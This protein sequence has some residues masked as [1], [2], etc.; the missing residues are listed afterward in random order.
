MNET[1]R[2]KEKTYLN[3]GRELPDWSVRPDLHRHWRLKSGR[4]GGAFY[5]LN[6]ELRLRQAI[7]S[8]TF[9]YVNAV[10]GKHCKQLF[11]GRDEILFRECGTHFAA[12]ISRKPCR[13]LF[14][15]AYLLAAAKTLR[16]IVGISFLCKIRVYA[17]PYSSTVIIVSS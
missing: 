16:Q 6:Y 15:A 1:S 4:I 9:L 7:S 17:S 10:V 14:C 5:Y 2:L 11:T 8:L 12:S 3:S 13:K